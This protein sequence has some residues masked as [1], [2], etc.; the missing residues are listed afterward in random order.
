M[1]RSLTFAGSIGGSGANAALEDTDN[2]GHHG[3]EDFYSLASKSALSLLH[4]AL[5]ATLPAD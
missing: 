1:W 4:L 5:V 3:Q 2:M